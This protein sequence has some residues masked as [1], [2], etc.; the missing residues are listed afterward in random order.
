MLYDSLQLERLI[1]VRIKTIQSED[2]T[3][4]NNWLD[5]KMGHID[6]RKESNPAQSDPAITLSKQLDRT[7]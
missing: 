2:E 4:V 7:A 3:V 5:I 1:R 6:P